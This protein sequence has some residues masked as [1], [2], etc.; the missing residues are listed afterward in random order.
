M[1]KGKNAVEEE[2]G[3]KKGGEPQPAEAQR[4]VE[5]R[6]QRFINQSG[7]AEKMQNAKAD[8]GLRVKKPGGERDKRGAQQ[9]FDAAAQVVMGKS[10]GS[11]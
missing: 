9:Y 2:V 4:F 5:Q 11:A 10:A 6:P 7:A 8:E 3:G 1:F